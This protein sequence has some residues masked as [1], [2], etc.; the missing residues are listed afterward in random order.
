MMTLPPSP[1]GSFQITAVSTQKRSD[2]ER[3]QLRAR[4]IE[5]YNEGNPLLLDEKAYQEARAPCK[6]RDER[7]FL[8]NLRAA[9][10]SATSAGD[11]SVTREV[12]IVARYCEVGSRIRTTRLVHV[13][14]KA[15][16]RLR[17]ESF[18]K[19]PENGAFHVVLVTME[20]LSSGP[21]V[22]AHFLE[23]RRW[24]LTFTSSVHPR[25]S[26]GYEA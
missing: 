12:L 1:T 24:K 19:V 13:L 11:E 8:H 4:L 18:A 20:R 17:G 10:R 25:S 3:Q 7:D 15:N 23:K 2:E 5:K 9:A 26:L 14:A 22:L 21:T 16:R 6:T